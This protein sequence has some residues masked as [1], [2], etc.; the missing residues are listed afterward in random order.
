MAD[1]NLVRCRSVGALARPSRM[2]RQRDA[3]NPEIHFDRVGAVASLRAR[4]SEKKSAM[5]PESDAVK[6]R[7]DAGFFALCDSDERQN[8]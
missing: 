4:F 6:T 3:K 1:D 8:Q 5:K 2:G 7:F